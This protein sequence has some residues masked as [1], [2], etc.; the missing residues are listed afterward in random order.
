MLHHF[1][2]HRNLLLQGIMALLLGLSLGANLRAQELS[3][4]LGEKVIAANEAFT[5]VAAATNT[6][7]KSCGEFPEIEGFKKVAG[8]SRSSVTN[9]INGKMTQ[10]E[11]L[12]QSYAPTGKGKF[13][14]PAFSMTINGETVRS[15]GCT[16][17]V[18]DAIKRQRRGAFDPFGNIWGS[19]GY[20]DTP[21]P[22]EEE[23]AEQAPSKGAF[24]SVAVSQNQVYVGEGFNVKVTFFKP[25][26]ERDKYAFDAS[27]SE[28]VVAIQKALKPASCW[29]ENT[30]ITRLNEERAMVNGKLYIGYKLYEATFFPFSTGEINLPAV[31][32]EMKKYTV[33]NRRTLFGRQIRE[34][35]QAF[36]S[37]P[38]RIVVKPL[39]PH[40]LKEQ[41][42]VGIYELQ[43][44]TDRETYQTG[45]AF[46]YKFAIRGRGNISSVTAPRTGGSDSL[47]IYDPPNTKQ[48]VNRGKGVVYGAKQFDYF[49]EPLEPGQYNLS[50]YFQWIYFNTQTNSY[51][52]L[53]PRMRVGVQGE[54]MRDKKVAAA[55]LGDYYNKI[56]SL[57]NTSRKF[58]RMRWQQWAAD[59]L[60]AVSIA[61]IG[62]L[63]WK[64]TSK[65]PK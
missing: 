60:L 30:P 57:S 56:S 10:S 65:Q 24:L 51:D 27:I 36:N 21:P 44:D 6:P 50:D 29:E 7:L 1:T 37:D 64:K 14:L 4:R 2:S 35:K 5:I 53:S 3:I 33:T 13:R 20:G 38:Q 31:D 34:G 8:T 11:S 22:A 12:T 43:E 23:A 46:T 40:P 39:P 16:I 26:R 32:L 15:Q 62:F 48:K 17:E 58:D 61:G 41:V 19:Y 9:I 55:D 59:L 18:G 25:F 28:Q 52:T 47:T 42:N 45:E 54:S 63:V 49:I